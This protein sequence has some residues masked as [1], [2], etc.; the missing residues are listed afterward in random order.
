MNGL[1]E[2]IEQALHQFASGDLA[3]NAK[4]LLNVLGYESKRT[5]RLEP[6][7]LDGFL[8]AFESSRRREIQLPNGHW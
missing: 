3:D 1:K 8:S 4:H 2:E 6:N 7:T 5:M